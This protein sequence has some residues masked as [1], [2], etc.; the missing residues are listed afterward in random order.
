MDENWVGDGIFISFQSIGH[1]IGLTVGFL[2]FSVLTLLLVFDFDV[3]RL[4]PLPPRDE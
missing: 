4:P 1:A 3:Q 2:I